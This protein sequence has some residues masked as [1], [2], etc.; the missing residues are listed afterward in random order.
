M[1]KTIFIPNKTVPRASFHSRQATSERT[2]E[3]RNA[4]EQKLQL[5]QNK[6]EKINSAIK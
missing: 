3:Y 4:V 1:P 6:A 5:L 2:P